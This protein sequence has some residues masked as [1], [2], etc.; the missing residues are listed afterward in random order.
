M[1]SSDELGMR[2]FLHEAVKHAE[3]GGILQSEMKEGVIGYC[4]SSLH[5]WG[6]FKC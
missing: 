1:N 5:V 3:Y 2:N 6:A 4:L